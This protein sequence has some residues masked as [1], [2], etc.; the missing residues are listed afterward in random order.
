MALPIAIQLYS[1]RDTAEQD[2][3]YTAK[4]LKNM[5]Y[6]GVEFAGLY[7]R[8]PKEIAKIIASIGLEP[9]SA[10]VPF[11]DMRSDMEKVIRD[12]KDIGCNHIAIPWLAECD[13]PNGANYKKT[14][15]DI[16]RFADMADKS[17]LTISYHNHDFEF[18]RTE[19]GNYA[20]DELYVSV[21]VLKAE[22]DTCW[23]SVAG[24]D[25]VKYIEK[26]ANR[27]PLLHLKDYFGGKTE[28]M[29]GLIGSNEAKKEES[30]AF[31][32]RPVG[33]GKIDFKSVLDAAQK[34]GVT[35]CIVEQDE[36]SMG[37]SRFECAKMSINTVKDLFSK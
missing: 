8:T 1:V 3:E 4:T 23:V 13:R 12:Y 19:N 15:E 31:E 16:S 27:I 34:C 26:Y 36:P 17:G 22:L 37:K 21:P 30:S 18:V 20:L 5:G 25:P 9:L 24:E 2:F 32:F 28:N 11:D 33:Y 35:W 14:V 10:H 29:Y 6:M 7:G